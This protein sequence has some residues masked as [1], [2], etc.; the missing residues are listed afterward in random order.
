MDFRIIQQIIKQVID[1]IQNTGVAAIRSI[2]STIT[3]HTYKVD[4]KNPVKS[5]TVEGRVKVQNQ[6]D[7]EKEIKQL[8]QAVKNLEKA[9]AP[10]KSVKVENF[11]KY[12]EFPK[13]PAFP[14]IPEHPKSVEVNNL[15]VIVNAVDELSNAVGKLELKPEIIVK[16]PIIPETVVNVPKA[17]PPVVNVEK[18]DLSGI[19]TLLEFFQG[20]SAKK[21][22]PTRLTDGK[23]FYKAV[24]RLAEVYSANNSSPFQTSSGAEARATVN[25]NN[26][27]VVTTDDTWGL[28]HS[29]EN[30]ETTYLG[31]QNVSGEYRIMKIV[32][33]GELQTLTYA[34]I[35]NNP[36]V[37]TYSNAWTNRTTLTYGL[38]AE[39]F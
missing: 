38:I 27:L 26:E 29:E 7:V 4:V 36:S 12:P 25:E 34:T 21:P 24:D 10:H 5:V 28:N 32:A 6:K 16:P 14:K 2:N 8:A 33:S 23:E 11:P 13:F 17:A 20:L 19:N 39:A 9:L 31:R 15:R 22:L 1:A 35:R 37:T 3:T 18:P 30:G